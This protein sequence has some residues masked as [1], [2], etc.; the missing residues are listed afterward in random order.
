MNMV[1]A[2]IPSIII[3]ILIYKADKVEKEPK[4]EILK[5]FFLGCLSIILTLIVSLILKINEIELNNNS[6]TQILIYSFIDI[7]LIE[8]FSK[9]LI[10]ILFLRKNKNY[11]YIFDSIVYTVFIALGFATIENILYAV[12]N[13][14]VVI[15]IRAITT[16]PA[17]VFFAVSL[18]YY[19]SKYKEK[20]KFTTLLL[21]L[22][23]PTLLH[24]FYD[25]CLLSENTILY[26]IYLLFVICL[27][28]FSIKRI[29]ILME[30]D[31]Q[32]N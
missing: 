3:G 22:I 2:I 25:F 30:N 31:K 24:G 23:V 13:D 28:I 6:I 8:E 16:V 21:S 20:P 9:W 1:L 5:A 15:L 17:H 29:K 14:I 10:S 4:K 32:F 11:N 19:I 12:D 18:G 26:L 27:Y 7:A